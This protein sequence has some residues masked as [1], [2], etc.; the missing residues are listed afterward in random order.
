[1]KASIEKDGTVKIIPETN[2][3]AYSLKYLGQNKRGCEDCAHA[4]FRV[5]VDWKVL[6][7]QHN[8]LS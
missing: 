2:E 3:E 8:N 6:E 7:I 5:S 1:M 4:P